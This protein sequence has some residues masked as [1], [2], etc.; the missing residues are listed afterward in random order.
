[1]YYNMLYILYNIISIIFNIYIYITYCILYYIVYYIIYWILYII[2]GIVYVIYYILYIMDVRM[3]WRS[4][5]VWHDKHKGFCTSKGD[6]FVAVPKTIAGVGY[7]K[8]IRKDT[9]S[10]T[11]AVQETWSSE[12]LGGQGF[13]VLRGVAFWS[14]RS[15]GLL[16]WCCVT[17]AAL[18][19][20]SL[21]FFVVSTVL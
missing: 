4:D 15:V 18:R 14:I 1:M 17:G 16:K 20:T 12:I 6:D 3:S 9:C 10:V 21:H 5:V 11:G 7:L 19:L 13:D 2:S 8:R